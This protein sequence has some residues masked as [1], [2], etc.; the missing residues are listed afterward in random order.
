MEASGTKGTIGKQSVDL[1]HGDSW[2]LNHETENLHGTDLGPLHMRLIGLVLWDS[3]PRE[4]RLSLTLVPA[5]GT[6]SSCWVALSG[7]NRRGGA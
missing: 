2:R 6:L 3:W 5:L 7:L 4:W 1:A